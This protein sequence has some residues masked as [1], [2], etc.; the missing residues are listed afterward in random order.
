MH[1]LL[2]VHKILFSSSIVILDHSLVYRVTVP[3]A[4]CIQLYPSE[5]GHLRLET[6]RGKA[7]PL[8]AWSDLEGR[9]LAAEVCSSAVVML[10]TTHSEAV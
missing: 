6:C 3:H 5:D 2:F 10:D 4:A 8:Q 9:L 1:C 7:V